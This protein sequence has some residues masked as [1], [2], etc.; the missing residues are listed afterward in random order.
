[1]SRKGALQV[2]HDDRPQIPNHILQRLRTETFKAILWFPRNRHQNYRLHPNP[3][4]K[5]VYR[6]LEIK[7]GQISQV[8]PS[9]LLY[10]MIYFTVNMHRKIGSLTENYG[11]IH[12]L[13]AL[14]KTHP[15]FPKQP[16]LLSL[17]YARIRFEGMRPLPFLGR[18]NRRSRSH[19]NRT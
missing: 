2:L 11:K 13:E 15:Q 18:S 19:P 10:H 4:R 1:M 8:S 17:P 6:L 3:N 5:L 14:M 12:S 9:P 7:K 16:R